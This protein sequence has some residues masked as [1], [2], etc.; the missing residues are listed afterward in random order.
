MNKFKSKNWILFILLLL[1]ILPS[2]SAI[3]CYLHPQ[4]LKADLVNKGQLLKP[5]VF[6][7]ALEKTKTWQ[8]VYLSEEKCTQQCLQALTQ[9]AKVRLSLGRHLYGLTLNLLIRPGVKGPSKNQ[10]KEMD[11]KMMTLKE[12]K[13]ILSPY[14]VWIVDPKGYVVMV[15][16]D[17]THPKDIFTDLQHFLPLWG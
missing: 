4:L 10:L 6:V 16:K 1:F 14:Q 5:P 2:I 11:I 3:W 17:E 12:R 13:S 9:L 15:Y 7:K 8:L